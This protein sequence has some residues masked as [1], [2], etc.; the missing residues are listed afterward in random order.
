MRGKYNLC[1]EDKSSVETL[2][3]NICSSKKNKNK[4]Y[5][6]ITLQATIVEENLV[7]IAV[8]PTLQQT[9]KTKDIN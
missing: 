7:Q 9:N 8:V 6:K 3:N 1:T 2:N 5:E 4:L